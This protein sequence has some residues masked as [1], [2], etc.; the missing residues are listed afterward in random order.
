[1]DLNGQL[2]AMVTFASRKEPW[3]GLNRRLGMLY[4]WSGCFA[5]EEDLIPQPKFKP[6]DVLA[7]NLVCIPIVIP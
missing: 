5:E 3:Y 2:H 1:M 6:Q 7:C 4:S